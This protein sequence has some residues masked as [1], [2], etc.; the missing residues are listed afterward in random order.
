MESLELLEKKE[1]RSFR[2]VHAPWAVG[3]GA[4][5]LPGLGHLLLGKTRMGTVLLA[6]ALGGTG[7]AAAA[8]VLRLPHVPWLAL[9]IAF[10]A[11]LFGLA[12]STLSCL[13]MVDGRYR[14][15]PTPARRVAFLNL[16]GY[17]AG[18]WRLGEVKLALA[19]WALLGPL[20]LGLGLWGWGAAA[21]AEILVAA[22]ALHGLRTAEDRSLPRYARAFG[23]RHPVARDTTP[24]WLSPAFYAHATLLFAVM[25]AS[26]GMAHA[27]VDASRVDRSVAV[28]VEPYYRNGLYDLS[29]E[30]NAPGWAFTRQEDDDFVVARHVAENTSARLSLRPRIP[31]LD[32]D[33]EAIAAELERARRAGYRLSLESVSVANLGSLEGLRAHARGTEEGRARNVVLFTAGHGWRRYVLWFEWSPRHQDF[34]QA[35]LTFLLEKLHLGS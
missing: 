19:A 3:L 22:A 6:A 26:L 5:L 31:W 17:G 29:L 1:L 8:V 30:F 25:L 20:H 27:W 32:S 24:V 10:L 12:D 9:R 18:Y 2:V 23:E 11:Y 35:E 21:M 34:A 33:E 16:L 4:L 15:H 28:R 14:N 7:L 13:E